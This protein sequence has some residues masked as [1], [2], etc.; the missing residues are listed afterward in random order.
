[1]DQ[2]LVEGLVHSL[3]QP[4]HMHLEGVAVGRLVA[5]DRRLQAF[6][7]DRLGAGAHQ[8]FQQGPADGR[9]VQLLA[10]AADLAGGQLHYQVGHLQAAGL[11]AA[12]QAQGTDPGH[13]L[14]Q[15]E[16]LDQIIVGTG[17]K[18]GELV[19]QGIQRGE[20]EDGGLAAVLAQLFAQLLA[21]QPRQHDVEEDHVVMLA[22][23][24]VK[25]GLAVAG[26][27][28]DDAADFQ[29]LDDGIG[30]VEVVLDQQQVNMH[31]NVPLDPWH[32]MARRIAE[33]EAFPLM[34]T[35]C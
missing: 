16:G 8:A 22:Q 35:R 5:P 19:R 17:G 28:A 26:V 24:Q 7:G 6:P 18:A 14:G 15:F 25:A 11:A 10:G 23:G 30:Q 31:G 1:M 12:A 2:G 9:Q 27:V 21:V 29:V 3:A 4:V 20:H 13:Q 34:F 32:S 33:A